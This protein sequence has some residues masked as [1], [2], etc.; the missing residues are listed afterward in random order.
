MSGKILYGKRN[1]G[2]PSII[3]VKSKI[4][5]RKSQRGK[6]PLFDCPKGGEEVNEDN[7]AKAI[8]ASMFQREH[9]SICMVNPRRNSDKLTSG[10]DRLFLQYQYQAAS[11]PCIYGI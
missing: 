4:G 7:F 11:D 6:A 5:I 1:G 8:F 9:D 2:K 10:I 3:L